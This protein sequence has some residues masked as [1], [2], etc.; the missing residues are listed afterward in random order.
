MIV[1]HNERSILRRLM[2]NKFPPFCLQH[3]ELYNPQTITSL[4]S[5]VGLKSVKV[6]RSKNYFPLAFMIRQAAATVGVKLDKLPLPQTVVG[7]RLGNMM[8]IA[9]R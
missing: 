8:T 4:L 2:G 7:L 5:R 9:G 1:T 3:P 6:R